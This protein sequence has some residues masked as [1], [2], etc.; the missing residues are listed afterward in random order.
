[1]QEIDRGGCQERARAGTYTCGSM[2][3]GR[4]C[5]WL[6]DHPEAF[7]QRPVPAHVEACASCRAQVDRLEGLLRGALMVDEEPLPIRLRAR[8]LGAVAARERRQ[9]K[10]LRWPALVPIAATAAIA[11]MLIGGGMLTMR[12]YDEALAAEAQAAELRAQTA[13]LQAQIDELKAKEEA[14]QAQ[15]EAERLREQRPVN[16][17]ARVGT[18][19]FPATGL[20]KPAGGGGKPCNCTPGDPLCSCW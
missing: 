12:F 13:K 20:S 15:I 7:G 3:E 8:I 5:T 14:L 11:V 10:T 4:P 1:L 19:A 6:Y 9:R 16:S 18:V 2:N 17:A